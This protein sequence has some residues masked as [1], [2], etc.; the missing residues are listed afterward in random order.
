MIALVDSGFLYALFD[1]DDVHHNDARAVLENPELKPLLPDTVLV[2]LA[3]LLQARLGHYRM[4]EIIRE[5]VDDPLFLIPLIPDDLS[6]IEMLLT[7]YADARLDFV[8]TSI[9]AIAERLNVRYILTVDRR[10]FQIIRP[11]H[12]A[13]FNIFP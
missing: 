8:D 6:R 10:D 9:V 5:M 7:E 13:Y 3:Y 2:E 11:R 12:C 4:R 1:I